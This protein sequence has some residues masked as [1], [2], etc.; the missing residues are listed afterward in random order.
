MKQVAG[1]CHQD[2]I[3]LHFEYA[4]TL[5]QHAAPCPLDIEAEGLEIVKWCRAN[6]KILLGAGYLGASELLRWEN[7]TFLP[8]TGM[9]EPVDDRGRRIRLVWRSLIEAANESDKIAMDGEALLRDVAAAL[10][11]A[12]KGLFGTLDARDK[13]GKRE[14]VQEMAVLLASGKH[15]PGFK[16]SRD[17]QF[18]LDPGRLRDKLAPDSER[19]RAEGCFE[20]KVQSMDAFA[21]TDDLP[22]DQAA[23]LGEVDRL[24]PIREALDALREE[25]RK[26][27]APYEAAFERSIARRMGDKVSRAAA[28]SRYLTTPKLMRSAE[29]WVEERIAALREA[30]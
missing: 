28:A 1:L 30:S 15:L 29:P 12:R 11:S 3:G 20:G 8:A 4:R 19:R 14:I 21:S 10:R 22:L 7:E 24:G 2:L 16:V 9:R 5:R 23:K 13:E 25:C 17:R 26:R 27:G 18:R 6:E